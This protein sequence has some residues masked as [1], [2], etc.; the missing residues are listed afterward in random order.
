MT[1]LPNRLQPAWPLVKAVHRRTTFAMGLVGRRGAPLHGARALPRRASPSAARTAALEPGAVTLHEAG[2]VDRIRRDMPAGSPPDHWVFEK[3]RQIDVPARF[4]LEIDRGMVV[5]DYGATITPTGTLDY[6]TSEY[7]GIASWRE[8]PIFL[9]TR[10]PKIEQVNGTV[11]AL[12]TRGGNTNYYH[13]LLDVLPRFGVFQDTMP[14]RTAD[15]LYVPADTRWQRELIDLAGLG[16]HTIIETRKH[17]AIQAEHLVVPCLP[18]PLEVAPQAT[19][20]WLRSRLTP[21]HVADKPK[22]IYVS[23]GSAPNTRRVV[24]EDA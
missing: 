16:G 15:A 10:L 8:H 13:F 12:G 7:F 9:R 19:I 2:A 21:Q 4:C 11:V 17:R 14:G 23:R 6:E 5:G 18:N 24:Q 20:D 1:R 22:R 3:K